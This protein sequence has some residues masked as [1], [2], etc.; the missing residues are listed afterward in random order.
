MGLGTFHRLIASLA[1][2]SYSSRISWSHSRCL[3][4]LASAVPVPMGGRRRTLNAAC[5][6]GM[7]WGVVGI[8]CWLS[9]PSASWVCAGQGGRASR[10]AVCFR[11]RRTIAVG[12]VR[13]SSRRGLSRSGAPASGGSRSGP[14]RAVI[15]FIYTDVLSHRRGFQGKSEGIVRGR[16]AQ[17]VVSWI[18]GFLPAK[19]A[20]PPRLRDA[21]IFGEYDRDTPH[22]P[23]LS[24]HPGSSSLSSP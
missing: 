14:W 5:L 6:L 11:R 4:R 1:G 12:W 8:V 2:Q 15:S 17:L 24:S 9:A 22:P 20:T 10:P 16:A 21:E 13:V 18:L 23:Q 7:R 3:L 19:S